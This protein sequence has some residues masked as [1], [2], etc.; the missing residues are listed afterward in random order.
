MAFLGF[1]HVQLA[2]PPGRE[3][4]AAAFYC[5]V[6]GFKQIPKPAHLAARGGCW[7]RSDHVE[8]HLGD[9]DPFVPARKA[10]PALLVNDLEHVRG[11]LTDA[12]I[13]IVLD[14]QLEGHERFYAHDPFGNRLEFIRAR[15]SPG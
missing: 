12:G 10:H 1:H 15:V 3:R 13:E 8:L 5:E 7:F 9:E 11:A 6:L 2:M 14:T 4:D